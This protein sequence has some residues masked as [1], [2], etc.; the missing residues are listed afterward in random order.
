MRAEQEISAFTTWEMSFQ[1]PGADNEGGKYRHRAI[2]GPVSI[3]RPCQN[4]C[5][6]LSLSLGRGAS[7]P[8]WMRVL[9]MI[10]EELDEEV[11]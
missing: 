8:E 6:A 9:N 10:D 5:V 7:Q 11:I 3:F 1:Q 2:S 4:Q